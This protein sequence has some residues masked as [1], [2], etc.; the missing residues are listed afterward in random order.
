MYLISQLIPVANTSIDKSF[1]DERTR[2][3]TSVASAI[4][5]KCFKFASRCLESSLAHCVKFAYSELRSVRSLLQKISSCAKGGHKQLLFEQH[6]FS[7][8]IYKRV[9]DNN[10]KEQALLMNQDKVEKIEDLSIG[11]F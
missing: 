5:R 9:A 2:K 6:D 7:F 10:S 8:N 1:T 4:P 3:I 11:S